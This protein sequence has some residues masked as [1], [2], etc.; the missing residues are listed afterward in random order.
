MCLPKLR[1]FV[2]RRRSD[3]SQTGHAKRRLFYGWYMVA[4]AVIITLYTGGVVNF[5][6][7]AVF[8]PIAEQ[9]KWSYAQISLAS[10]LRG[11]EVGLLSAAVGMLVDKWGPRKLIF[12]G[13]ILVALG[14]VVLSRVSSLGMF[15]AA[16]ALIALG[17]SACT[18]VVLL[19]AVTN[20]F[21]KRAGL[22][23]GV[24]ASGFG[25][26][27]TIVPLVTALI[28]AF[29]WR[30]AMLIVGGGMLLICLPLAMVM[31]HRPEPYGY[32]PDGAKSAGTVEPVPVTPRRAKRSRGES[33]NGG[34]SALRALKD[35]AFWHISLS[36]MCHS[37][38]V[39]AVVTHIMPYLESLDIDRGVASLVAL[40]L[41]LCSIAGRLSSGSLSNRFGNKTMYSAS[42]VFM[43]TG[44]IF[45]GYLTLGNF[46]LVVPFV[47][48]FSLGWGFS[49]ISRLTLLR[50]YYGRAIFGA[51]LGFNSTV[52]M[53]GN[54]TGAPIAG[55]VYDRWNSYQ[56]AWLAFGALT[57]LGM[58]LALT[59]PAAKKDQALERQAPAEPA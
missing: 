8:D 15:Y 36:S 18:G 19:T 29:Q 9:F 43:T 14:F 16:F 2:F 3:N 30:N 40:V 47:I 48:A 56:G 49:V 34:G 22:A 33:T 25:L 35:R 45:F 57:L 42:F 21:D 58:V 59:S 12:G 5:G 23:T 32:L 7:T 27:G 28:D 37:F 39:G 50:E 20:W 51:V 46:W 31:R 44:L 10:S 1:R 26:G 53:I 41:P 24:V 38:V 54:T 4:A 11:L 13:S 55:W 52:M 6:F 17:M